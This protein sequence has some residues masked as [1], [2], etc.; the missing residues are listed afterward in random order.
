MRWLP[1][2]S[3]IFGWKRANDAEC[4]LGM[5]K[6]PSFRLLFIVAMSLWWLL[7]DPFHFRETKRKKDENS[8]KEGEKFVLRVFLCSSTWKMIVMHFDEFFSRVQ[9]VRM[10]FVSSYGFWLQAAFE[11]DDD[12]PY[13]RHR[14]AFI[15]PM[16][17]LY[18]T[19]VPFARSMLAQTQ[20]N[21]A[22]DAW[23]SAHTKF[24]I[25]KK[26]R[27]ATYMHWCLKRVY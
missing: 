15:N 21:I 4:I 18:T 23:I 13:C 24:K 9:F 3:L 17:I 20:S 11:Y 7:A 10:S 8:E 27:I 25:K 16:Q 1:L 14:I 2:L 5:A 6:H 22:S 26:P 19:R 12:G